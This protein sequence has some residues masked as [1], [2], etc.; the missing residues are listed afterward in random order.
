M[1]ADTKHLSDILKS[2]SLDLVITR[3][4]GNL[5]K[6]VSVSTMLFDHF[7]IDIVVS[8]EKPSL[9]AK[10]VSYRKFRQMDK[11]AF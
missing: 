8:L 3:D 7:L 6:G 11:S 4:V 10:A 1:N 9:S 2:G 5:V